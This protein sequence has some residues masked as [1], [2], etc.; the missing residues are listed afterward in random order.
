MISA[1]IHSLRDQVQKW[2]APNVAVPI[3]V[4]E[5]G[6]LSPAGTRYVLV[7]VQSTMGL[8]SMYFFLHSDR[9]WRV[10]P[11]PVE[12]RKASRSNIPSASSKDGTAARHR[13]PEAE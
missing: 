12:S 6:R 8:R 5:H 4:T 13:R 2:L 11:P 10:Y 3:R 9:N 1:G 7:E